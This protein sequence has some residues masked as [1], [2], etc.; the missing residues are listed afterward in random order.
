MRYAVSIP[1]LAVSAV[2]YLVAVVGGLLG[3]A[4]AGVPGAFV[5]GLPSGIL[6]AWQA[7]RAD[8]EGAA[9]RRKIAN[10]EDDDARRSRDLAADWATRG[11]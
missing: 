6:E 7:L 8:R 2:T 3:M 9:L 4:V 1:S 10:L 11:R 5:G